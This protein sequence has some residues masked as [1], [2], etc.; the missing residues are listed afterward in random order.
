MRHAFLLYDLQG[1]TGHMNR[2]TLVALLGIG[3][4][5][6]LLFGQYYRMDVDLQ[7][8]G[9]NRVIDRVFT[10][11]TVG[12]DVGFWDGDSPFA[13]T[14]WTV[15]FK[16][17]DGQYATN[18][19][20]SIAGVTSSN[21]V[22]FN[23][24]SNVFYSPN[25]NY[26]FSI[27]GT[28]DAGRRA[29]FARGRLIEEYDP[30]ASEG[31][32]TSSNG[33]YYHAVSW[34]T[35]TGDPESNTGLVA[36]VESHAGA[37]PLWTAASNRVLYVGDVAAVAYGIG[38]NEAYRGDWGAAVSNAAV[39]RSIATVPASDA[40]SAPASESLPYVVTNSGALTLSGLTAGSIGIRLTTTNASGVA[41]YAAVVKDG[42]GET[43]ATIN[44]ACDGSE[45]SA[46]WPWNASETLTVEATDIASPVE[47]AE[48]AI[49]TAAQVETWADV[50]L[51]GRTNNLA[52]QHLYVDYPAA[53]NEAANR[54]YADDAADAALAL[55]LGEIATATFNRD[56]A[57][58]VQR[59]NPRFD[60][61]ADSNSLS[62]LY[63]G[64][65]ALR[66]DGEGASVV[67]E[68]RA[69]AVES[70]EVATLTV[71]SYRG[72]A[73]NLVPEVTTNLITGA[74]EKKPGSIVSA[75]N[76]D[77][78][79][80]QVVFTNDFE[81]LLYVRLV[82]VSGGS[83]VPVFR[84]FGGIAFGDGEAITDWPQGTILGATVN[85]P[86]TVETNDGILAFTVTADGSG[87][88]LTNN[89]DMAKY[90]LTNGL[91]VQATNGQF[92]TLAVS[93][94]TTLGAVQA[95]TL[96]AGNMTI[97]GNLTVTGT[98]YNVTTVNISTNYYVG[99]STTYV[100][101]V[102]Y[103][104]NY[105]YTYVYTNIVSTNTVNTYVDVGGT[106][107]ASNSAWAAFPHFVDTA[108]GNLVGIGTWDFTGATLIGL[109]AQGVTNIGSSMTGNGL[110]TALDVDWG[111]A[112]TTAMT[113]IDW[114]SFGDGGA[115]N[116]ANGTYDAGT[117]TLTATGYPTIAEM[118]AYVAS[119][120]VSA[121]N[122]I[123]ADLDDLADVATATAANGEY[124]FYTN[125]TW[126]NKALVVASAASMVITQMPYLAQALVTGTVV[127]VY[128]N[129]N[130]G[131]TETLLFGNANSN[132]FVFEELN[133]GTVTGL[134][135]LANSTTQ[136]ILSATTD[137]TKITNGCVLR[138]GGASYGIQALTGGTNVT[139]LPAL[140]S[141]TSYAVDSV[142]GISHTSV[143]LHQGAAGTTNGP[144]VA[145]PSGNKAWRG[146]SVAPDGTTI[147]ATVWN[148]SIWRSEWSAYAPVLGVGHTVA[149]IPMATTTN[150]R[151]FNDLYF[152]DNSNFTGT[153]YSISWQTNCWSIWSTNSS[154][155]RVVASNDS[156]AWKWNSNGTFVA[157]AGLTNNELGT[158]SY[159]VQTSVSNRMS[160]ADI[161]GL[162]DGTYKSAG[163]FL[164][165]Y[166]PRTAVTF[167]NQ[168]TNLPPRVYERRVLVDD[169]RYEQKMAST[170]DYNLYLPTTNSP[171][172][173]VTKKVARTC[174]VVIK[175]L[176]DQP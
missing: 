56:L 43:L 168:T 2:K 101:E 60:T 164:A 36:F 162:N 63:G 115:T 30:A 143:A 108:S 95:G 67:P 118:E 5:P 55:A 135:T 25:E 9:E 61:V 74:W 44:P 20:Q 131:F 83:G 110:E 45:Q 107:D 147:Y 89:A 10:G 133:A 14:N 167:L 6:S 31:I 93:G 125:G 77:A 62:T 94:L 138:I 37:E 26:Y 64:S 68:I 154:S 51:V 171:I 146:I 57:G 117:R 75:T 90:S 96:Q 112:T 16:Y 80:A 66:L 70:G 160:R 39:L 19:M 21:R 163:G 23:A 52:E 38:T 22:V 142:R 155:W 17:G 126:T 78:F 81:R 132:S 87:F 174:D 152:R 12:L 124:L 41:L 24:V 134:T 35:I 50:S 69:F 129:A 4:I 18:D 127:G 157:Q 71:W 99:V 139:F 29:T 169:L 91:T 106:W 40:Y 145:L 42:D 98:T 153:F 54:A 114:A 76:I 65:T 113:N 79:T 27:F 151:Y 47:G 148:G 122:E 150:W 85:E 59:W 48:S 102:R 88:P 8:P 100:D 175:Y 49:I 73:T 28:N 13:V 120:A 105:T 3:L 158:L 166:S 32:G 165:G 97:R 140:N 92:A 103:S 53:T 119:N 34:E 58:Y 128:D 111:T 121:T 15:W 176:K 173:I 33:I 86:H 46:R 156:G 159:A 7:N 149:T 136:G 141:N 144:F 109:P 84:V 130:V 104:T 137:G 11:N 123:P 172:T 170:N 161:D 1:R 116:M 82:D 72:G